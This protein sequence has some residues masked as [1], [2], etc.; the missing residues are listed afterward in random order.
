MTPFSSYAFV[1]LLS[2]SRC[3]SYP[4]FASA[5]QARW[6]TLPSLALWPLHTWQIL[7]SALER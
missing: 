5:Q 1:P 2:A 3:T 7:N 4:A 6:K